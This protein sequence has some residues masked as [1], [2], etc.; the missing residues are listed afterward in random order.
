MN[1]IG[2]TDAKNEAQILWTPDAELTHWKR[3]EC[4]ERLQAKG[5]WGGRGQDVQIA[6]TTQWT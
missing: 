3:H 2:S 6:S 5:E 4:L 1:I